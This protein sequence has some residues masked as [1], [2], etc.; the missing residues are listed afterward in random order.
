MATVLAADT[1]WLQNLVLG[2]VAFLEERTRATSSGAVT[3]NVN[4]P[5][6]RQG[7]EPVEQ[8]KATVEASSRHEPC[9]PPFGV[10]LSFDE[11]SGFKS[12]CVAN[13]ER[14][15]EEHTHLPEEAEGQAEQEK[16]ATESTTTAET[17]MSELAGLLFLNEEARPMENTVAE[18]A[19]QKKL[20]VEAASQIERETQRQKNDESCLGQDRA[21]AEALERAAA[22]PVE[23]EKRTALGAKQGETETQRQKEE[24]A[25]LLKK[26]VVAEEAEEERLVARAADKQAEQEKLTA[27]A[28]KQAEADMW[29]RQQRKREEEARLSKKTTVERAEQEKLAAEAA[30]RAEGETRHPK[31]EPS[32]MSA[33]KKEEEARLLREALT[34]E[35]EEE[36]AAKQ[37][38]AEMSERQQHQKEEELCLLKEAAAAEQ[39]E[40]E[41]PAVEGT[42]QVEVETLSD[43]Y[44]RCLIMSIGGE[45][46]AI[47]G[48]R[49]FRLIG[50]GEENPLMAYTAQ[51]FLGVCLSFWSSPTASERRPACRPTFY[52]RTSGAGEVGHRSVSKKAAEAWARQQRQEREEGSPTS[53]AAG[54]SSQLEAHPLQSLAP[55]SF[56]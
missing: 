32:S 38:E 19:E 56:N 48:P 51:L 30:K 13:S 53:I 45:S 31:K 43:K 7:G 11:L 49:L 16:L 41:K 23:Q 1:L 47:L 42:T 52:G 5:R 34:E 28:P 36:E 35:T 40:Q 37:A 44:D 2:A 8:E 10:M 4:E 20:A 50:N 33:Y 18:T 3:D 29:E 9:Q 21:A 26:A 14:Q 27:D 17:E 6:C 12:G 55:C 25:Y 46:L 54:S 39:A 24:D 15:Q 22:K